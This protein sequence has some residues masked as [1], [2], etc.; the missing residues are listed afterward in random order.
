[1]EQIIPGKW[2]A[3]IKSLIADYHIRD[4]DAFYDTFQ[5]SMELELIWF[6]KDAYKEANKD[7]NL[8]EHLIV[9]ALTQREYILQLD[10]KEDLEDF[11]IHIKNAWP[12]TE[13][14][15]V[16]FGLDNDQQY[17]TFVPKTADVTNIYEVPVKD[18]DQV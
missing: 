6:F 10:Y 1:L 5:K 13:T 3:F 12:D 15:L 11:Y 7:N 4:D 16:Q 14:K 8:L 2:H 17:Y 18:V 9:F